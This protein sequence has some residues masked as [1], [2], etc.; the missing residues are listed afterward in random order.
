MNSIRL[1]LSLA[2]SQGWPIYQ[3]DVKSA[4]LHGDIT[5]EIYM[6]Q[7]PG[8]VQDSTLVCR[9]RR[10]L[11][12]LKQAPRAWYEKMD[13]FL[14]STGFTRC[15]SD[16][17][18]YIQHLGDDILIPFLYVDDLILLGSSSSMLQDVKNALM[19]QFEMTDLGLLHYFLGL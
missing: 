10:S 1:V 9:L 19:D 3:M 14:L 7:P 8:F 18:V 16:P 15:H 4:F 5:E 11:Y 12:G 2:A 6:E 13:S 17:T